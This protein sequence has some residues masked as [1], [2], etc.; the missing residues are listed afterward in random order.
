MSL[1]NCPKCNGEYVY[2]DGPLLIC[3]ECSYEWSKAAAEAEAEA[4]L[5]KDTIEIVVQINGKVKEKL[6]V[7]N[8]LSRE[9]LEKEA[10]SNDSVKALV[11][12]KNIV[13]VIAVPNKLV[14]IVVK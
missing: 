4:A 14:N 3:P 6:N 11:E 10:L 2:E 12:G 5:V 8:N 9:D 1:P 13:K 7:S